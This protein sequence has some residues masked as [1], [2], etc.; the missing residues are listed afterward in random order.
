[1]VVDLLGL[2]LALAL[3]GRA[4]KRG[5]REVFFM[6]AD[7]KQQERPAVSHQLSAIR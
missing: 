1:M 6:G 2:R 4:G 5:E 7:F 3:A